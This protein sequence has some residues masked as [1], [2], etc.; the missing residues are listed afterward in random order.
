ME[1]FLGFVIIAILLD[2][3]EKLRKMQVKEKSNCLDLSNYLNKE[4]YIVLNN[5]NVT[6]SYLF[7]AMMKT[8]GKI[9]DYDD[10]WFIFNYYNKSVRK[11]ITQ[12]LKISD[13]KSINEIRTNVK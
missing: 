9:I 6:D 7:S 1:I 12:Y 3:E 4:V 11:N 13:L 5:D 2:I 10:K 8:V